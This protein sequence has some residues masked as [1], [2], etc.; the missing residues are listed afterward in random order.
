MAGATVAGDVDISSGVFDRVDTVVPPHAWFAISAISRYL[1][2]SF[3]VLLFPAVGVLG[4]AWLRIA[5]AAALFTVFSRP[6]RLWVPLQPSERFV[7]AGLGVCLALMNCCFYLALARL[8]IGLVAAIEFLGTLALALYGLRTARNLMGLALAAGGVYLLID[9]RWASDLSGLTLAFLNGGLFLLYLIL[10]HRIARSG[11]ATGI[12]RLA[13]AM[14]VAFVVVFPIGISQV[15]AI[16]S[17]PSLILAGVGVGICSSVVPYVCDQ[18]AMARLP[19]A[20]FALLLTLLPATAAIMGAIVLAQIPSARDIA[21]ILLVMAGV[22]IHR[23]AEVRPA[24]SRSLLV[25]KGG[26][27]QE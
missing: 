4:V 11:A 26:S 9:V 21:G 22:A 12:E 20:S 7:L 5:A 10:G 23:P 14:G 8:P 25:P 18:L 3:A 2:P 13:A 15:V 19:R 16:F 17:R 6:W 24:P 1:G 27:N